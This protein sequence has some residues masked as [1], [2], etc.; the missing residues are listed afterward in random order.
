MNR[1][2]ILFAI[3]AVLTMQ[4]C[5]HRTEMPDIRE[6][7]PTQEQMFRLNRDIV[8]DEATDIQLLIQ[9]YGWQMKVTPSGLYYEIT[10]HTDSRLLQK[11]ESVQLKYRIASLDGEVLYSSE[12]DGIKN[13]VIEKSEEPMGLH[14][15]LRLMRHGEYAHLIIPAH[16]AYGNLGD[17]NRIPG[18]S[19][20]VC[21]I[22]VL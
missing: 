7:S 5:R 3:G 2:A 18:F 10:R 21:Y 1:I 4:G 12:K 11:G 16:L 13:V 22:E 17:G 20:L 19:A 14:E 6:Q 8:R 15:A 9:R